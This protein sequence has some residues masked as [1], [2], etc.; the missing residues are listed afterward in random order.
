MLMNKEA[1]TE[2]FDTIGPKIA[3]RPGGYLRIIK[4]GTRFGDAAETAMIELVDYNE[5]YA[6]KGGV[7]ETAS[8]SRRRKRGKGGAAAGAVAAAATAGTVVATESA[9]EEEE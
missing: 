3:D 8:K 4:T 2:L 9:A 7:T 1:V 6:P 5:V